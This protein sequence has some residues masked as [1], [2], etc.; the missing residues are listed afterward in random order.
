MKNAQ[1]GTSMTDEMQS[2][3]TLDG[4]LEMKANAI[5]TKSPDQSNNTTTTSQVSASK[6]STSMKAGTDSPIVSCG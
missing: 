1:Y 2:L 4:N 3:K 5:Q 6:E